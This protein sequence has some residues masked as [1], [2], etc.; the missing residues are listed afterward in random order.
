MRANLSE[1]VDLEAFYEEKFRS[2]LSVLKA[3]NIR[4]KRLTKE[5]KERN[6]RLQAANR[7]LTHELAEAHLEIEML[8]ARIAKFNEYGYLPPLPGNPTPRK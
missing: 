1:D 4:M 5:E 6:D 8:N 7:R 3:N 2:L